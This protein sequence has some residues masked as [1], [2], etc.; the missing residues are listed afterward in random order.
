VEPYSLLTIVDRELTP[1][2]MAMYELVRA[3][4]VPGDVE[5]LR[6]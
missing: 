5:R 4:A 1:A 3:R 6:G 2:A